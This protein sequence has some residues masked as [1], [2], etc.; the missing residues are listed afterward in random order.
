M[1][2]GAGTIG[3]KIGVVEGMIF[4]RGSGW[5]RGHVLVQVQHWLCVAT[6]LVGGLLAASNSF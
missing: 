6:W 1:G 2:K 5:G 3:Y 4:H